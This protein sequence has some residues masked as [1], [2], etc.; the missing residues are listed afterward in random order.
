M[1]TSG[2]KSDN[3]REQMILVEL[4]PEVQYVRQK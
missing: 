2:A 4:N 1:A 3:E